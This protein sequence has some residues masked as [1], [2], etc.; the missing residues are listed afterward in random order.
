MA[1]YWENGPNS[2]TFSINSPALWRFWMN[3]SL[4]RASW[5]F[6]LSDLLSS[7]AASTP[8]S[9]A[10]S[11]GCPRLRRLR[12]TFTSHTS[13]KSEARVTRVNMTTCLVKVVGILNAL[14]SNHYLFLFGRLWSSCLGAEQVGLL[15]AHNERIWGHHHHLLQQSTVKMLTWI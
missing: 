4:H 8:S 5:A 14:S 13:T 3:L 6:L 15:S 12:R 2:W 9:A 10:S 7:F 1:L 11:C